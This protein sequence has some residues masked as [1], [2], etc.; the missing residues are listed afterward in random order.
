MP[1]VEL[2]PNFSE[3]RDQ[4]VIDAIRDAIAAT[5]GAHVLDVSSDP[6]HHRT[7]ITCRR[8]ARGGGAGGIRRHAGRP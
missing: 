7:V 3:G 4:T 8:D 2:V 1:L 5:P 6:S